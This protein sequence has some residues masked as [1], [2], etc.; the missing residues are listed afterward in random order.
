MGEARLDWA[1]A[2]DWRAVPAA[3]LAWCIGALAVQAALGFAPSGADDWT[4]LVQVRALLDGQ[5]FWDVTQYRMNPPAGFSM[6]W[7]RLVDLPIAALALLVGETAAMALVPLLWLLPALFAL[8]AIMLRLGFSNG[9][10][11]AGLILM[12]LMPLLPTSFAPMRID[13]HTP[14]AVLGLACA[15]LLLSPSRRS[16]LAA[17]LCAS[18]WALI[19]LE[20]LPLIAAIAALYGLRYVW[21]G[22]RLLV[23]FLAALTVASG[24]LGYAMRGPGLWDSAFCDVLL[25]GH[26][27]A[28]AAATLAA[29]VGPMLPG[30]R[31]WQWRAASVALVP[32]F[33]VPVAVLTLGPCLSD[34]M[35]Q[36]DPVLRTWWHG[37]IMEG[38]PIWRQPVSVMVMTGWT[39]LIVIAAGWAVRQD[40]RTWP[41][42]RQMAWGLYLIIALAAGAYSLVLMRAGVIAQLLTIPAA[43]WLIARYLPRARAVTGTVPRIAATLAV[44][45]FTTPMFA[46]LAAKPLD[47]RFPTATMGSASRAQIESG[48]CDY[49]RL[50]ALEAGQ[51]L[52][53]LDAAPQILGR[54]DH[55]VVAASYHRNQGPMSDVLAAYTGSS[56]NARIIARRYAADYVVACG[57]AADLALYRTAGDGNFANAVLSDTPPDWLVLESDISSGSLRVYRVR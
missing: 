41:A 42:E 49:G 51:V 12:P 19:S 24:V 29:F 15:A 54:T 1:F 56:E 5:G 21:A 10:I 13:H 18:A 40:W 55:T 53:P 47:A 8:R 28:F 43:A 9:A 39:V 37:Y 4:R 57:S 14:Q 30:Q 11:A 6:H 2:R 50:S 7:S 23:P 45:G 16:A 25:P 31:T 20:A 44:F 34:P 26:I 35:A 22:D 27:A 17:G 52:A 36:L 32:L 38:L 46:S 48:Q 3:W 33:A